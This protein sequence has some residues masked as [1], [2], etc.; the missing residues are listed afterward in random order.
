M[1]FSRRALN[2]EYQ[3]NLES[4]F[5]MAMKAQNQC[6][7]TLE[8][9]AAMKNPPVIF[10]KQANIAHGHQQV[11]NGTAPHPVSHAH[12][13]KNSA[14]SNELLEVQYGER[15][16]RQRELIRHW[17][18]WEQSTGGRTAE[19]KERSSRNALKHGGRSQEWRDSLKRI[20]ALLRE[21]REA[22]QRVC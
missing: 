11:N 22:L 1:N 7:M 12:A 3:N 2:Q 18:P 13:E 4:F 19:G 21:Q 14:S 10:A 9:L 15:R 20:H 17:K 5:A 8:A 6:R 16:A